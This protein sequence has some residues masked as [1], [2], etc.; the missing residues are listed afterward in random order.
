[1]RKFSAS[2]T[3]M[4]RELPALERFAAARKAGF[5]KVEIQV[6]EAGPADMLR[7]ARQVGVT[8]HLLNVGMGDFIK[9]GAGLIGVPGREAEFLGE[10]RTALSV[11]KAMDIPFIHLGPSRIPSDA[12]RSA[13]MAVLKSNLAVAIAMAHDH[14]VTLLLEPL[15]VADMPDV[16]MGNL[17]EAAAMIHAEFAGKLWLMFDIYHVV[18]N[19][20]DVLETYRRNQDLIKHIQFSDVPGRHEPGTGGIDFAALFAAI[21]A[22]GYAG[23]FGAEYLPSKPTGETFSWLESLGG[24]K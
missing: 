18:R 21:E 1:M 24:K 2:V 17:D 9:G 8:V 4:F 16:L 19:G 14:Q 12:T 6:L 10:V 5:E 23:F 7:E 15:N 3:L 13:C 20:Q 11:A 22:E